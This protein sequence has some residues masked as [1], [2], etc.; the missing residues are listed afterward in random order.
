MF[1]ELTWKCEVSAYVVWTTKPIWL[2]PGQM[3]FWGPLFLRVEHG[4]VTTLTLWAMSLH[5]RETINIPPWRP[6]LRPLVQKDANTCFAKR[7][8]HLIWQVRMQ[9]LSLSI[10]VL[11][12]ENVWSAPMA[13]HTQGVALLAV[14]QSRQR[15]QLNHL[16]HHG[17][18]LILNGIISPIETWTTHLKWKIKNVPRSRAGGMMMWLLREALRFSLRTEG[19]ASGTLG[20]AFSCRND[21]AQKLLWMVMTGY[22]IPL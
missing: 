3:C 13:T 9:I 2:S 5:D 17:V 1:E 10:E 14:L 21:S 18:I 8:C 22:K 20:S 4:L 16:R 7:H 19:P 6:K 15:L 12:L 11:L